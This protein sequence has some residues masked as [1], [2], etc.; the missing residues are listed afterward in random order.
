MCSGH[1]IGHVTAKHTLKAIQKAKLADA[2]A[3]ATRSEFLTQVA[4]AAY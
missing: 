1:E 3:K 2:G 4:N